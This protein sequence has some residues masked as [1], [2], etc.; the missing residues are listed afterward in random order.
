M[1]NQTDLIVAIVAFVLTA[2]SL[3]GMWMMKRETVVLAAP[4]EVTTT[5]AVLPAGDVSVGN[6]LPG[7]GGG[8]WRHAGRFR[9]CRGGMMGGMMGGMG[10][11]GMGPGKMGPGMMGPGTMGGGGGRGMTPGGKP[12]FGMAKSGGD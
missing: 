7:G 4:T 9:R 1:K 11:P 2:G 3:L 5:P 10:G 8:S 6:S 12:G